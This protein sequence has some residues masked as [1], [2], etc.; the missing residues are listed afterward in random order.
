MDSTSGSPECSMSSVQYDESNDGEVLDE[1]GNT[2]NIY[3]NRIINSLDGE[4]LAFPCM[5]GFRKFVA[6]FDLFLP[7]NI[8]RRRAY[9]TIIVEGL[10]STGRNLVAIVRDVYVCVGSFTYVTDFVVLEDIREIIIQA[11]L[12]KEDMIERERQKEASKAA[13]A[14]LYDEV[15]GTMVAGDVHVYKLTRLDGSYRNFLTFS[16]MLEVLDRQYVLDL[17]KIVMERFPANGPEGYDLILRGDLK[18]LMESSEH[19]E[20]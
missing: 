3:R 5:I 4:D 10:N 8:I 12:D 9:N 1:F 17:H 15:L 6:Y 20:I 14:E 16:R 7:M 18:T 2:R 11:E 13:L 19:D